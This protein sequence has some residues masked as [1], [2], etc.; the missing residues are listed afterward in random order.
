MEGGWTSSQTGFARYF[1]TFVTQEYN[2]NW[3][4]LINTVLKK[5]LVNNIRKITFA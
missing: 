5:N 2:P 1:K 3:V 4:T